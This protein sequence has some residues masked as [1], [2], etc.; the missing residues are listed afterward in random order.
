MNSRE[1]VIKTLNHQEPDRVPLDIGGGTSST[2]VIEAYD[3]LKEYLGIKEKT[4]V[5]SK[6]FR[7]ARIS[8]PVIKE[9]GSDCYPLEIK[10][11]KK[12]KSKELES[13][14]YIDVWGIEWK[15]VFNS[16]KSCYYY[17]VV[18]SPLI[19]SDIQDLDKYPWPDPYDPGFTEGLL[20][21]AEELFRTTDY[22]LI[23]DSGFKSFWELG[24]MLRG[25]EQLLV[26]LVLNQKFVYKLMSILLELNLIITERFLNNVG[27]F[28]QVFR[29]ADDMATQ[30][31]LIMSLESYRKHIKPFYKKYYELIRSKTDAKIFYHSCGNITDLLDDLVEIGV[32]IINPVQVSAIKDLKD[33]KKKYSDKLTFWGGIDTQRIL[34]FG[35]P[36][37]V[38]IEVRNRIKELG[39][40]G[41]YVVASVHNI[42]AD[43]PPENILAMAEASHEF[44]IY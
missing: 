24:Y 39:K 35:T 20:K 12:L 14:N 27:K 9:L 11:S 37:D 2:I 36:Q 23:G 4:V 40:M 26:D 10:G 13:G 28:I 5:M 25:Y 31:G 32:E 1:R 3:K 19:D 29:T 34:P 21:D 7:L 33:L 17:D 8:E 44:G 42:Q 6:T 38:R 30:N 15:K 43:V 41:G 22:A 16:D 18:K